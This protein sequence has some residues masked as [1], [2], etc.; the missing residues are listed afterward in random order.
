MHGWGYVVITLDRRLPHLLL[1][2]KANDRSVFGIRTS[3]LPI[4]LARDQ[5]VSLGGEFDEKFT[6]YAP[7]DY[8]RDAFYVFTPDVMALFVDRLGTYDV[9]LIDD[10]M[11]VYGSRFD[12]L[13]PGTYAWL[14]ELVD[15][16]VA[17]TVRR[18]ERY[19]DE[20]AALEPGSGQVAALAS[21]GAPAGAS[22]FDYGGDGPQAATNVVAAQGRRLRGKRWGT[23][24][25]LALLF[26]LLLIY[27]NFVAPIF[28]WP[29]LDSHH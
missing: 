28:G 27:N 10:T 16:V 19:T 17:R 20:L 2:A 8:G 22:V 18:T 1:D 4:D 15:T 5:K 25:V 26:L 23:G 13:N 7:T 21:T 24:S 29:R 6:L 12:L 14:Q 11:F 3:N 9:E